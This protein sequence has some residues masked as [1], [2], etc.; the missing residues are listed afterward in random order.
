MSPQVAAQELLPCAA[1][2][3][4]E[5]SLRELAATSDPGAVKDR[6]DVVIETLEEI[7]TGVPVLLLPVYDA[8]VSQL[9]DLRAQ[10][11]R[12]PSAGVVRQ[13]GGVAR[14]LADLVALVPC[15]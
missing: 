5:S 10:L 4:L 1:L 3:E 13:I 6:V 14:Q 7:R 12:D 8:L 2:D 11:E 15:A 9:K